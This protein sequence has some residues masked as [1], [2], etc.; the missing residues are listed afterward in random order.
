MRGFLFSLN[1]DEV[2]SQYHGA[3]PEADFNKIV[4]Y[5]HINLRLGCEYLKIRIVAISILEALAEVSG[6]DAAMMLFLA[7]LPTKNGE[8][9][10]FDYFL[11]HIEPP[12]WMDTSST[13]YRLLSRSRDSDWG[14]DPVS[15]PLSLYV[16]MS[17]LPEDLSAA[18]DLAQAMVKEQ[19]TADEYLRHLNPDVVS[20]VARASAEIVLTRRES[21]LQ[22]AKH[23]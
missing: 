18:Y 4:G 12:S 13:I 8:K 9:L 21:L 3:P 11:P 7:E 20:A 6:G 2:F 10:R 16:Y 19:I 14:Y 17:M 23:V 1:P 15:S 5:A 22:Y